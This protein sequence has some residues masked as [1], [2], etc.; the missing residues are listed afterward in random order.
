MD[1]ISRK[2]LIEEIQLM[3][4][5][6]MKEKEDAKEIGDTEVVFAIDNQLCG[7][8]QARC[9]VSTIGAAYDVSK[10]VEQLERDAQML[11]SINAFEPVKAWRNDLLIPV[12]KGGLEE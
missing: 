4:K 1:L 2:A 5:E 10:T 9:K 11:Y 8:W 7:L 12:V 6:L 3:E